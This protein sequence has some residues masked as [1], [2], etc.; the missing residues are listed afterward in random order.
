MGR[1]GRIPSAAQDAWSELAEILHRDGPAPCEE[2]ADP[3]AWWPD[4][5]T[6][7]DDVVIRCCTGCP[8]RVACVTYALAAGEDDGVWGGTTSRERRQLRKDL[9]ARLAVAEVAVDPPEHGTASLYAGG[10][11]CEPCT[12]ANARKVAGW[13]HRRALEAPLAS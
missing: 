13:R 6:K 1:V 10:C 2:A 9:L 7:P 4:N 5:G 3:D 12:R 8:A 11:R